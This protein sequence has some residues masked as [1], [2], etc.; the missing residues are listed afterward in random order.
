[1]AQALRGLAQQP[2]PSEVTIPGLLDGLDRIRE[3]FSA[4][5]ARTRAGPISVNQAAE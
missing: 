2:R 5:L 1:M 4:A 3:R